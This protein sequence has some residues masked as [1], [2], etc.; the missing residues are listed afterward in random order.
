M[1]EEGE[2]DDDNEGEE[3]TFDATLHAN[4]NIFSNIWDYLINLNKFVRYHITKL[5]FWS[6]LLLL[7]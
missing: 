1:Q 2:A 6:C 4:V 3:A 7:F 5:Q